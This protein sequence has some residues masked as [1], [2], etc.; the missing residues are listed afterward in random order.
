MSGQPAAE[1]VSQELGLLGQVRGQWSGDFRRL[2]R[3]FRI[4]TRRAGK[5]PPADVIGAWS[6]LE[7]ADRAV[8][9]GKQVTVKKAVIAAQLLM[10]G[11]KA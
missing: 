9:D 6:G 3:G 8:G 2:V 10:T 11:G 1:A 4:L 7:L 5:L